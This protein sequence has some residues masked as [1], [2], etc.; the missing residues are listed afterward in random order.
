M[1]IAAF[2]KQVQA[3]PF[4]DS[5]RLVLA[6]WYEEQEDPRGEFI[7]LQCE[8]EHLDWDDPRWFE[9]LDRERA[10]LHK[11]RTK[12]LKELPKLKGVTWGVLQEIGRRTLWPTGK[13][14]EFRRGFVEYCTVKDT[15]TLRK[16]AKALDDMGY[17]SHVSML[18]N[19]SKT[20]AELA[21]LSHLRAVELCQERKFPWDWLAQLSTRAQLTTLGLHEADIDN[22][23]LSRLTEIDLPQLE[24]LDL[25]FNDIELPH[26]SFFEWSGFRNL[27][28]LSLMLNDIGG[29]YSQLDTKAQTERMDAL[30]QAAAKCTRL[31]VLDLSVNRLSTAQIK[32]FQRYELGR[33]TELSLSNNQLD[34]EA[35]VALTKAKLPKIRLLDLPSNEIGDE[36]VLALAKARRMRTL[37]CLNLGDNSI[38]DEG[39]AAIAESKHLSELTHLDLFKNK[40][41]EVGAAALIDSEGFPNMQY[42]NLGDADL[43]PATIKALQKRFPRAIERKKYGS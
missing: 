18:E 27:R 22:A 19:N 41:G 8:R 34:A 31:H 16:H 20:Y 28:M 36:G 35:M 15:P 21:K 38:T 23:A 37:R 3:D 17:V 13:R 7:R 9:I 5:P 33:L 12:W 43:A 32:R 1:S 4:N 11:N 39:V 40:F 24:S 25:G 42:L 2:T 14:T 6:D 10:L 30:L 26:E 29:K